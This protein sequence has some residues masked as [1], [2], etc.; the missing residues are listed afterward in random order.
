MRQ[1]YTIEEI[2]DLLLGQIDQVVAQYAPEAPGA[3][4]DGQRYFTLNPGRPDKSV[5]SF[6]IYTSGPKAGFWE[7]RA[8]GDHGGLL[9]LIMLNQGCSFV[10]ALKLARRD[11]GLEH[12]DPQTRAARAEAVKRQQ[13]LRRE[14]KANARIDRERVARSARALWLS[15]QEKIAGTPVEF[16]LRGA[17]GIDLAQLGRQPRSLRY[18]PECFYKHTDPKTGEITQT[19]L[20]AM[21][22]LITDARGQACGCHR[23][24]L[25]LGDD[26]KWDK[27]PVPAPKKVYGTFAGAS[28]HIWSGTGPRGG[29]GAPLSTCPPDSRIYIAEG[30]EDALSCVMVL[31]EARVVAAISLG[32]LGGVVLPENVAEVT[33]IADQDDGPEARAQLVRA[34]GAH[35]RA[36]R[37][38][39]VWQNS[40]GGKDLNDAWRSRQA[41]AAQLGA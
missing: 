2:K 6:W 9:D 14:A 30:I 5:G 29:K 24:Y 23:T 7:D 13:A 3:H 1:N 11:L 25:R 35:Q 10:D 34:I 16:Y 38:T 4:H 12:E 18:A 15:A 41:E 28:I 8:T 22:G 20:P 37:R 26:G 17:R 31:P 39:F 33:L 36:G 32:N 40:D 19:K 21:L 27:A